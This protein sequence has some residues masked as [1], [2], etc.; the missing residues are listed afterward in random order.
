MPIPS[1]HAQN[2][3]PHTEKCRIANVSLNS[4]KCRTQDQ[5]RFRVCKICLN[6]SDRPNASKHS[7]YCDLPNNSISPIYAHKSPR[8]IL[9]AFVLILI[10]GVHM[11]A[12]AGVCASAHVVLV[13]AAP[14][15]VAA[16][17]KWMMIR[18][19][20][21]YSAAFMNVGHSEW[22]SAEYAYGYSFYRLC[23]RAA[24]TCLGLYIVRIARCQT[25]GRKNILNWLVVCSISVWGDHT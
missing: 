19:R 9:F 3:S 11:S 18:V 17:S 13:V 6:C 1:T 4:L 5:S 21:I 23:V 10:G 25:S 20:F 16:H 12:C 22:T 8:Y 15:N 7:G 24:S 2:I 14:I